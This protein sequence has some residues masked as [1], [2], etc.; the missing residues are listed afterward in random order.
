MAVVAATGSAPSSSDSRL[1]PSTSA[2]DD[3]LEIVVGGLELRR[4]AGPRQEAE[5]DALAAEM[6]DE[7]P[8][9][10]RPASSS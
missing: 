9:H 8:S 10:L 1:C 3:E 2:N 7:T 6:L 4:H 5:G